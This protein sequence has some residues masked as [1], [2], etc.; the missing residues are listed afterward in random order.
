MLRDIE[1]LVWQENERG[2]HLRLQVLEAAYSATGVSIETALEVLV[3]ELADAL[4]EQ[5][6]LVEAAGPGVGPEG[7]AP[8]GGGA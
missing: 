7:P 3:L 5:M 4:E 8:A 2:L 6:L 1:R